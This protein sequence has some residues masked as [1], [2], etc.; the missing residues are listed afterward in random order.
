MAV[1]FMLSI[2]LEYNIILNDK[3]GYIDQLNDTLGYSY[4]LNNAA[5]YK[6]VLKD[7]LDYLGAVG[8]FLAGFGTVI[9]AIA[10]VIG[11]ENWVSKLKDTKILEVTWDAKTA[12]NCI[13]SEELTWYGRKRFGPEFGIEL[14]L[15]DMEQE[16]SNKFYEL[17]TKCHELDVITEKGLYLAGKATMY[18]NKYKELKKYFEENEGMDAR[19]MNEDIL[20]LN[21]ERESI[22]SHLLAGL[23]K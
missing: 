18:E 14:N 4:L 8:G 16:L 21:Q 5:F 11:V 17:K 7:T 13:K 10:A 23:N 2:Y 3:S 20:K 6:I 22:S 15:L 19:V 1:I 12:F 9:A